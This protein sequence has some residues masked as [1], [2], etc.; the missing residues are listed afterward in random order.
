MSVVDFAKQCVL[1]VVGVILR[2]FLT[3]FT[4]GM[5]MHYDRIMMFMNGKTETLYDIPYGKDEFHMKLA[6]VGL[7]TVVYICN[8][9]V[10]R[11]M[12]LFN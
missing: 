9:S 7:M 6:F 2:I 12:R 10:T 4:L 8:E 3:G 1:L 11:F 5:I